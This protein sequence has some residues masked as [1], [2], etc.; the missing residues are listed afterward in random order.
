MLSN[1]KTYYSELDQLSKLQ[2]NQERKPLESVIQRVQQ[3]SESFG[4]VY[5]Q[6]TEELNG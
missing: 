4:L 6:A 1:Q 5:R 2:N 3:R